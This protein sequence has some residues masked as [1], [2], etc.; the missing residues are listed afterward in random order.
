[1]HFLKLLLQEFHATPTGGHIGVTKTLARLQENFTCSSIHQD[2]RR[3]IEQCL[4]CQHTNYIT[5]KPVGL[6]AP[7]PLPTRPWEDFSL[8][9]IVGL[10]SYWGYTTILVVVDRFL[11]GIHLGL[12]LPHYTAYQ[13]ANLFLDIVSKLHD[14]PKSLVFDRDPLFISKFWQELFKLS[15]TKLHF[16]LRLSSSI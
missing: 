2:V 7:F 1:M 8:D 12:L 15:G 5:R 11:K 14:M 6:L 4:D 10:P 16:K 9:F 3:F 13:V